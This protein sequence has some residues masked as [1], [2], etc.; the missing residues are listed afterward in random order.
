VSDLRSVVEQLIRRPAFWRADPPLPLVCV[1]GGSYASVAVEALVGSFQNGVPFARAED[2]GNGEGAEDDPHRELLKLVEA[3][4]AEMGKPVNGSLLPPPRFPLAQFVIW[5]REQCHGRPEGFEGDWP[6]RFR[7]NAGYGEFKHQFRRWQRSKYG[8]EHRTRTSADFAARAAV[9]WVPVGTLAIWLAGTKTELIP[10]DNLVALVPWAVGLAVMLIGTV[11]QGLMS[12]TGSLFYR[13]FRRQPY[14]TRRRFERLPHYALRV[15]NAEAAEVERLLV[16]ALL[17]DLREAYKKRLLPWPNWGRECYGLLVLK[18]TDP[19][20]VRARFL[21]LMEE[22]TGETGLLPPLVVVASVPEVAPRPPRAPMSLGRVSEAVRQWR[23]EAGRRVPDLRLRIEVPGPPELTAFQ[24]RRPRRSRAVGYWSVVMAV[25]LVLPGWGGFAWWD[26]CGGRDWAQMKGGECVGVLN[27]ERLNYGRLFNR[28][29]RAWLTKIDKKNEQAEKSG[30]YVDVVLFGEYS[31]WNVDPDDPRVVSG[32]SELAAAEYVQSNIHSSPR[33]RILVANGGDDFSR[34]RE[35]AE[36]IAAMAEDNR[37]LM[38]VVGLPRSLRGISEAIQV[39]HKAK[40]PMVSSTATADGMGTIASSGNPSQYYFHVGPTSHREARLGVSFAKWLFR[41]G[42][43][44]ATSD[45]GKKIDAVIVK[46]RTSKDHYTGNLADGFKA[47]LDEEHTVFRVVDELPYSAHGGL[48]P[49]AAGACG[50]RPDVIF[51]AGRAVDF[52]DFLTA[53]EGRRCGRVKVIAADDVARVMPNHG[54]AIAAMK[55]VE[56]YYLGLA[57]RWLW[58]FGRGSGKQPPRT[59]FANHLLGGRLTDMSDDNLILTYDAISLVYQA[60]SDAFEPETAE[61]VREDEL[62]SRGEIKQRLEGTS[63]RGAWEGTSGLI[64]FRGARHEPHDK[65]IAVMRPGRQ[66]IPVLYC[67]TLDDDHA[68]EKQAEVCGSVP[69]SASPY[70][71]EDDPDR[72][73]GAVSR[74]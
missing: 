63:L 40:I 56:V 59:K 46:D 55:Q 28:D 12:I 8:S 73:D 47:A 74:G 58:E 5:A 68:L 39:L 16:H 4:A 23:T 64:D 31:P 15:A 69:K 67:G 9:A 30:N 54:A 45:N 18:I 32:L 1:T 29:V 2:A 66:G 38:G 44:V 36:Q 19:R 3:L 62:P 60:I 22:T 57:G 35:A 10:W 20:G 26:G 34:A 48:P 14:L 7:T 65:V 13:S 53:V 41:D 49:A 52:V 27:W 43:R 11:F 37:K 24:P 6:P 70:T 71:D 17:R 50:R 25:L 72:D 42:K 33:L 21:R 61:E 51:Y